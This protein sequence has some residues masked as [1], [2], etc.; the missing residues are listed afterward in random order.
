M[1]RTEAL[2]RI[3]YSVPE[4]AK[5]MGVSKDWIYRLVQRGDLAAI[6]SGRRVLIERRALDDYLA[7]ARAAS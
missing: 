7:A 5:A 6:H 2:P 1:S 3:A 4:V